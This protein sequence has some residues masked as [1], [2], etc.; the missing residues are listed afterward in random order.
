LKAV[1]FRVF[2][3]VP[4]LRQWKWQGGGQCPK[5]VARVNEIAFWHFARERTSFLFELQNGLT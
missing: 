3:S 2:K 4:L 1:I 5:F